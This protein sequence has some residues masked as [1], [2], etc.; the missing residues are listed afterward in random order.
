MRKLLL[1]AAILLVC[2]PLF[3][4]HVP[5]ANEIV[6]YDGTLSGTA[7]GQIGWATPVDG[8]DWYCFDVVSGR[9]VT[10][11]ASRSSGDIVPNIGAV[12]GLADA[13]AGVGSLALIDHTENSSAASATLTF[14]PD[15]SGPVTI[16][17][18]TFLEE[19]GGSYSLSV[20]GATP[21]GSCSA[22]A[23]SGPLP[24]ELQLFA[25]D[26]RVLHN[27]SGDSIVTLVVQPTFNSAVE[28]SANNPPRDVTVTFS[29]STI[30]TPGAGSSVMH[31][32]VGSEAFPGPHFLSIRGTAD[33]GEQFY[34]AAVLTIPCS[35]PFIL[36]RPSDQ[37]A[38]QSVISGQRA[39]LR[40]TSA[41]TAP[42]SYQWFM[43]PR[44]S[45]AFPI[46]GVVGPE[47]TTPPITTPTDFWVRVSN[48]CGTADS[49][50]ATVTP[51]GG[52]GKKPNHRNRGAG[53]E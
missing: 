33:D 39:V 5:P 36:D 20:T 26:L 18:S 42:L 19:D 49:W 4:S 12:E 23:T 40:V 43:G 50:T 28:L 10:L 30:P 25:S 48:P 44:G 31:V 47:M 27:H 3:A 45:T 38:T 34:G 8:Y 32:S 7:T 11:S 37:P 17:V 16:W 6:T 53:R 13:G 51:I 15:F 2:A 24:P 35:V 22:T 41:G 21:R 14:T 29:P 9:A 46:R 52:S 1:A